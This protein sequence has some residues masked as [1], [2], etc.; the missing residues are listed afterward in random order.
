[1]EANLGPHCLMFPAYIYY[2]QIG[3]FAGGGVTLAV[4]WPEL[5]CR[6]VGGSAAG[7]GGG[8]APA[9]LD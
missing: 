7:V 4:F 9:G 5:R 1:M 3:L 6:A 8:W 2:N